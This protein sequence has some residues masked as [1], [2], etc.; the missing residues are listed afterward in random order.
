MKEKILKRILAAA[1]CLCLLQGT[2]AAVYAD[3]EGFPAAETEQDAAG[4]PESDAGAEEDAA[5]VQESDDGTE[6]DAAEAPEADAGARQDAAEAPETDAESEPDAAGEGTDVPQEPYPAAAEEEADVLLEPQA[7]SGTIENIS[8][9]LD[10]EGTLTVSGSGGVPNSTDD[11]GFSMWHAYTVR[12]VVVEEGVTG[13]GVNAFRGLQNLVSVTLPSSVRTISDAAFADCYNLTHIILSEGLEEIGP[14]AF[15]ECVGLTSLTL[16]SSLRKIENDAF[17]GCSLSSLTLLSMNMEINESAFIWCQGLRTAGG[18]DSACNIRM[19]FPDVLENGPFYSFNYLEE[20]TIPD[21][22]VEIGDAVFKN[23]LSLEESTL[24]KIVIPDSVAMIGNEAFA[25]CFS[26]QEI[27]IPDSVEVIGSHAFEGCRSLESVSL[28]A[29]V[30]EISPY[31]FRGCVSLASVSAEKAQTVGRNT[32]EGCGD[33]E[34]VTLPAA[35][36]IGANAF[37]GCASLSHFV[38]SEKLQTVETAAS[39]SCGDLTVDFHG[40]EDDWNGIEFRSYNDP[41]INARINYLDRLPEDPLTLLDPPALFVSGISAKTYTGSEIVLP[42]AVSYGGRPLSEGREYSVFY[43]DN[44]DAGTAR[45]KV[46]G[47]GAYAGS[48]EAEFVIQP[49]K[50]GNVSVTGISDKRYTGKAVTQSPVL[51]YYGMI[52]K[53]GTDYTVSYANNTK[54]GTATVSFTGKGNYTGTVK[55]TFRITSDAGWERLAGASGTGAL[56]TQNAI[57]GKIARSD[58]A[59]IVTNA[60][61]RDALAA[62]ALAGAH[63]APILMTAPGSLSAL[64]KNELTRLGVKTVYIVGNTADVSAAAEEQLR[65]LP[66]VT[67]VTRISGSGVSGKAAAAAQFAAETV[68]PKTV[69]I[70]TQKS[71]KDALSVSPYAFAAKAPIL[72]LETNLTLSAE[73]LAFIKKTGATQAVIVGGP[74][75]V[76]DAVKTQLSKNTAVKSFTRLGGSGCYNTSRIIAEWEMGKLANGTGAKA[77]TLYRYVSVAF[78]P[79]VKLGVNNAGVSRGDNWKDAVAGSALCGMNRAILLLADSTNSANTAVVRLYKKNV[80]RGFVFGGT[81]AVP[82]KV[83][84]QFVNASK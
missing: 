74:K 16:P 77:G 78:Q 8:W 29:G 33:L 28:P 63:N 46:T 61:F 68:R 17:Y 25:N 38:L 44:V 84:N 36:T 57:T 59:V 80:A 51:S 18:P 34:S 5:G 60:H 39:R 83:Y 70:A 32:F 14:E 43:T 81:G 55:K 62:A 35:V 66:K 71:F 54:E 69:I 56:G 3:G 64:T 13:I 65:A 22:V 82:A 45:V 30:R 75:A 31:L 27:V 53:K 7:E 23:V 20:V 47:K 10:D 21:N 12:T 58:V 76:P 24:R 1:L 4:A 40:S 50:I 42:L 15:Y 52:L 48:V 26:L 49:A 37:S 19:P 72:Y 41:L 9:T 73:T 6:P 11:S 67:E 2:L 79:S